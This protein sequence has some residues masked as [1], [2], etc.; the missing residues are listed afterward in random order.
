[1]QHRG[2]P[3]H[4]GPRR[5]QGCAALSPH[6]HRQSRFSLCTGAKLCDLL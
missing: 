4:C 3:H 5:P 1:L 2:R 6:S